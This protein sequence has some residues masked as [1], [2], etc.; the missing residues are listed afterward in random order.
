MKHVLIVGGGVAGLMTA[1]CLG[2]RGVGVTL[3]EQGPLPNP[4][5]SSFDEHRIIRHAYGPMQGY[6]RLMPATFALWERL[7]ADL[8]ARHYEETGTANFMR[9]DHGWYEPSTRSLREMGIEFT[10]VPMADVPA[11]FPMINMEGLTRVVTTGGAGMLFPAAILT[12]LVAALPAFGVRLVANCHVTA[13]DSDAGTVVADHERHT[14]D[15]VVVCAG[16]W[17]DRLIPS[18]RGVA[19]PSRQAVIYLAPPSDLAAAWASAPVLMNRST[20]GG[21]YCLPPRRGARLKVGDHTFSRRG[22][23]DD[24]RVARAEDLERLLPAL[25][26]G[27]RDIERYSVLERRACYYTVTDDEGFIVRPVGDKVWVNSACSGHGFKLAP[28]MAEA[29]AQALAGERAAAG[30]PGWAAGL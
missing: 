17:V 26:K 30:V 29:V 12:A 14:A 5:S 28:T 24:D 8:G 21:S 4:R 11:R 6:A 1:W 3:F 25:A 9:D 13:V 7:W 27:Y 22:D 19:V 18:L 16:A 23:P 20:V 2:R 10:D 15:A